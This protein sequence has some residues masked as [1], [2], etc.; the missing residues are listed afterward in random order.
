MHSKTPPEEARGKNPAVVHHQE[1]V[2]TQQLREVFE[3]CLLEPP[4]VAVEAQHA[5]SAA[6][7]KRFLR[8]QFFI[9]KKIE[10]GNQHPLD[11][12]EGRTSLMLVPE[13]YKMSCR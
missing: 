6:V 8:N 7:G 13:S 12:I 3:L 9:K 1:I 2:G 5:G 10:V 11:Y 4:S